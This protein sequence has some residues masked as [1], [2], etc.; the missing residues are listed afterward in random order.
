[1]TRILGDGLRIGYRR[2]LSGSIAAVPLVYIDLAAEDA[3]LVCGRLLKASVPFDVDPLP[4]GIWR[5]A[6]KTELLL[7]GVAQTIVSAAPDS[8]EAPL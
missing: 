7:S 3:D 1:M 8:Q 6:F 4:D 5:I 2:H